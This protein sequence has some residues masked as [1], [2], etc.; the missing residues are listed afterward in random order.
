MGSP[1]PL[2]V[3]AFSR[4]KEPDPLGKCTANVSTLVPEEM[5]EQF[6]ALA[7][8]KMGGVSAYLRYMIAREIH[9]EFGLMRL[10]ANGR[11]GHSGSREES[12]R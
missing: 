7:V 3:P 11:N 10:R 5:A 2:D 6:T 12:E 1:S 4:P 9:G 8:M